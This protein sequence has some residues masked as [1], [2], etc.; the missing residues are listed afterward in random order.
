MAVR[1]LARGLAADRA[2]CSS[3]S[4]SRW[5]IPLIDTIRLSFF[6]IKGLAKPKYVGIGNYLKLFADPAFRNTLST[7]LIFTLGT[8]VDLGRA[9]LGARHAVLLCAAP[10]AAVPRA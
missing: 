7:T 10:D 1:G 4:A 6:D 5:S 9:R 8:T 3:C 2:R